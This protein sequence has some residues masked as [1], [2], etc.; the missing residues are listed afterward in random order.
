MILSGYD[1][2]IQASVDKPHTGK[3]H[4]CIPQSPSCRKSLQP[5]PRLKLAGNRADEVREIQAEASNVLDL[6]VFIFHKRAA[7]TRSCRNAAA[8][9]LV[10]EHG[11]VTGDHF[12]LEPQA[13]LPPTIKADKITGSA[14]AFGVFNDRVL[15]PQNFSARF[16]VRLA[17]DD[18]WKDTP[19]MQHSLQFHREVFLC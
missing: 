13:G 17:Q 16:D 3:P 9:G 7:H 2:V 14:A 18:A 8:P 12:S 6:D 19:V 5:L 10:G 4:T 1:S 11:F 15:H